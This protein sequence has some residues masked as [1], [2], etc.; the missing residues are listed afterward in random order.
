[1]GGLLEAIG[2]TGA[3]QTIA[4]QPGARKLGQSF[5]TGPGGSLFTSDLFN[6]AG[7]AASIADTRAAPVFTGFAKNARENL[8]FRQK[9]VER[10]AKLQQSIIDSVTKQNKGIEDLIKL[11]REGAG[12]KELGAAQRVG[13]KLQVPSLTRPAISSKEAFQQILPALRTPQARKEVKSIIKDLPKL[14]QK[15]FG[16]VPTGFDVSRITEAPTGVTR[17]LEPPDIGKEPKTEK[18]FLF[19]IQRKRAAGTPLS[20][21]ERNFEAQA[22]EE[23]KVE[24]LTKLYDSFLKS[25]ELQIGKDVGLTQKF[26]AVNEASD[27]LLQISGGD[28]DLVNKVRAKRGQR[29]LRVDSVSGNLKEEVT[30]AEFNR[31]GAEVKARNPNKDN[32]QIARELLEALI[33]VVE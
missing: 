3:G 31:L 2:G 10:E 4:G 19:R 33:I 6:I 18:E 29:P 32:Q 23:D 20:E 1:M 25:K 11:E 12:R 17:V 9:Q 14:P 21:P 28:L 5:F 15:P 27:R 26:L 7:L 24:G 8:E 22:S 30:R 16:P 13:A